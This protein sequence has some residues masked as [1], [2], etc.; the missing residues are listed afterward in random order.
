MWGSVHTA[1]PCSSCSLAPHLVEGMP[2][3]F[4][5]CCAWEAF[6][7]AAWWLLGMR[8]WFP[9]GWLFPVPPFR[10]FFQFPQRLVGLNW[11]QRGLLVTT[12]PEE[13]GSLLVGAFV[14]YRWIGCFL[15]CHLCV[16][17]YTSVYCSESPSPL[18]IWPH[19]CS[20]HCCFS[21]I[22]PV[23]LK[24]LLLHITIPS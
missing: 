13:G 19:S 6:Q 2:S 21:I 7:V 12:A 20:N 3:E 16:L 9:D 17:T 11:I 4:C 1:V 18:Q 15:S 8:E 10:L 14:F 22:T 23:L 24:C 5:N